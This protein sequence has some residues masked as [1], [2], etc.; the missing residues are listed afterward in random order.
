MTAIFPIPALRD[1]Y[2]WALHDDHHAAVVDPGD[3][4]PVRDWLNAN[5][6]TLAAILCTHHHH[7]HVDGIRELAQVYNV[8]VYGPRQ[9]YIA[10]VTR[11]VG[12]GDFI[13]LP[14]AGV[15]LSVL[16]IPGHT[17]GHIAYLGEDFVFCGD[18]LFACGCGRV[19]DG[20]LE[21]LH[22]SLRRLAALPD[23][24]RVFCTHEYTE[25]NIRFA[26]LCEP[27]NVAL[28]AR[29]ISAQALR[30]EGR[31]TL[32]STIALEKATN[33]FFRC[34]QPE[35]MRNVEKHLGHALS[36]RDEMRVFA[37]LRAWRNTF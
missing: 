24:T 22:H 8:P 21:Q 25:N 2:I 11:A 1:N 29:Q 3:A 37:A 14:F 28:Q 7:D 16:D 18:T 5:G 15:R 35:I 12:E 23:A 6:L 17:R 9:E 33:P 27:G 4:A 36:S 10:D 19:F 31:P 26:L 34:D 30:A 13:E 20:S 32:P